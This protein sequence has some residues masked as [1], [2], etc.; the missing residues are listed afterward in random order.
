MKNHV[1]ETFIAR[2]SGVTRAGLFITLEATGAD[3]LVPIQSLPN[4]YY[5]HDSVLHTLI[6]RNTGFKYFLGQKLEVLLIE[7]VPITGCMIF[8]ILGTNVSYTSKANK[9]R[10]RLARNRQTRVR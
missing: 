2:V 4:D 7:T 1:G 10:K 9:K 3:G 6:G 8:N 5:E